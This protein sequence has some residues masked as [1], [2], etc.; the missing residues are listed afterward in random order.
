MW[1]AIL[2]LLSVLLPL[3][4]NAISDKMNGID[5]REESGSDLKSLNS[6][7]SAQD[8]AISFARHDKRVRGLLLKSR[9]RRQRSNR[10]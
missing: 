10:S 5:K 4:L 3:A 6:A 2:G 7:K 9:A 8:V 1:E